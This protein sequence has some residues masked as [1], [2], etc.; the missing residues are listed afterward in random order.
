MWRVRERQGLT[1]LARLVPHLV[2]MLSQLRLVAEEE[3]RCDE[4]QR[5]VRIDDRRI[6][7]PEH[8][9]RLADTAC[10]RDR[11]G[12]GA[13]G[14]E[15]PGVETDAGAVRL[16]SFAPPGRLRPSPRPSARAP[17][18]DRRVAADQ[19]RGAGRGRPVNSG[20]LDARREIGSAAIGAV[21]VGDRGT[22]AGVSTSTRAPFCRRSSSSDRSGAPDGRPDRGPR[23]CAIALPV[24]ASRSAASPAADATTGSYAPSTALLRNA[25]RKLAGNLVAA[26]APPRRLGPRRDGDTGCAL[27][28]GESRPYKDPPMQRVRTRSDRSSRAPAASRAR[29][30]RSDASPPPAPAM[31]NSSDRRRRV[32]ARSPLACHSTLRSP[33][34]PSRRAAAPAE[35]TCPA[36]LPASRTAAIHLGQALPLGA[37]SD[38]AACCPGGS[39]GGPPPASAASRGRPSFFGAP[40]SATSSSRSEREEERVPVGDLLVGWPRRGSAQMA[41]AGKCASDR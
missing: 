5:W 26:V 23:E 16:G 4:M 25:A 10:N 17:W 19:G 39:A 15:V 18:R 9:C 12:R 38:V 32:S 36:T 35:N 22:A 37:R 14:H 33:P 6:E 11:A 8:G 24:L 27:A 3:P 34:A 29:V 1:E 31:Y 41:F 20:H 13:R 40:C 30:P 28:P 7:H 21:D 2:A